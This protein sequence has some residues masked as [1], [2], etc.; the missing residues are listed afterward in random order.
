MARWPEVYV[1]AG[2]GV[3]IRLQEFKDRA[4]YSARDCSTSIL[5]HGRDV[6]GIYPGQIARVHSDHTQSG[7]KCSSLSSASQRQTDS[8]FQTSYMYD[9]QVLQKLQL[10]GKTKRTLNGEPI[11]TTHQEDFA[12]EARIYYNDFRKYT[13]STNRG[14][15]REF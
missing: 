15:L 1:M 2:P 9:L 10:K 12:L 3:T 11:Q 7:M 6:E 14:P 8:S 13:P 4:P 5:R